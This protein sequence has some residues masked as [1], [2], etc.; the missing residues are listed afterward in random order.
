MPEE[1]EEVK[2]YDEDP[3]PYDGTMVDQEAKAKIPQPSGSSGQSIEEFLNRTLTPEK[4]AP[5]NDSVIA[6]EAAQK[7]L[8]L[9]ERNTPDN[10]RVLITKENPDR[11]G[12]ADASRTAYN[13][14]Q[15]YIDNPDPAAELVRK[16]IHMLR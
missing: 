14:V 5:M 1:Y 11:Y 16:H 2:P 8:R 4:R 9:N 6:S 10:M 13:R 12:V 7:Q 3:Q 15:K